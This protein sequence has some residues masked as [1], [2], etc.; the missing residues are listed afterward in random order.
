M[1]RMAIMSFLVKDST[2]DTNKFRI[3]VWEITKAEFKLNLSDA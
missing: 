1:Y 2:L 3:I